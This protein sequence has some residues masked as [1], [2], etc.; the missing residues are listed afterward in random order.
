MSCTSIDSKN[1]ATLTVSA[2]P[3]PSRYSKSAR[4]CGNITTYRQLM[5]ICLSR[6]AEG[7]YRQMPFRCLFVHD[8]IQKSD[9]YDPSFAS[10]GSDLA[11]LL[12]RFFLAPLT[13]NNARSNVEK[14]W[15]LRIENPD[16]ARSS[17][18]TRHECLKFQQILGRNEKI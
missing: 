9:S 16:A 11:A 13:L 14:R 4:Q 7:T 17:L 5:Q 1:S 10:L 18:T 8:G 6:I 12:L 15:F 2:I 3:I